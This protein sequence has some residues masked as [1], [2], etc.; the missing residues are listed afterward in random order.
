MPDLHTVI[1]ERALSLFNQR[2]P[3]LV[4]GIHKKV[5]SRDQK[6]AAFVKQLPAK[7]GSEALT[8]FPGPLVPYQKAFASL[9]PGKTLEPINPKAPADFRYRIAGGVPM[10][11]ATLSSGEQE[12]VKVAF[13]LVW[14]RLTHSVI[15]L[16]EPE[17]HLH[18]T[19]AFRLIELLKNFGGGT[20]QL[21][22]F[23]HSADLISTYYSTGS[24]FFIDTSAK[25]ENQG[26]AFRALGDSH[27]AVARAAGANLG[28]FAVGKRLVMVEGR[29]SSVDRLVYHKVAQRSFPDAYILPIGSVENIGALRSVV[30]EL[31]KAVF[32]IDLFLL[33]D[34]DGLSLDV[35]SSLEANPRFRCL[36]RRHVENYLLD[37]DVLAQVASTFYLGKEKTNAARIREALK[38]I[39]T[40]CLTTAVLWNVRERIRV[41]G[42]LPQPSVRAV[43]TMSV[44]DFTGRV[45]TGVVDGLG[46]LTARWGEAGVR[47]LV[48]EEHERLAAD[49][50]S[51]QWMVSLP[52]KPIFNRFCGEFLDSEAGRV[53]EAYVDIAIREK[54]EVFSEVIKILE[55]FA[56][57]A[58]TQS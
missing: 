53:R 6:I 41:D 26:H 3:Q 45:C 2:W 46:Q 54:P 36:P 25:A 33:R 56:G 38:G 9:L 39:A 57:I 27:A 21:V 10:Q 42:A 14:K 43:D 51:D 16:D 55:S 23:T 1:F 17:L 49:L 29:E 40:S 47:R 52:G 48:Q 15:L 13:D 22:M 19:L 50:L 24:V 5:A 12:V 37:A 28:L 58:G 31:S 8:A 4:N 11:F 20:N 7:V 35:V 34:R 30:D 32:G 44:A 18:P